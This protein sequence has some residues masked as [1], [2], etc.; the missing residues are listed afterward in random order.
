MELD[1]TGNLHVVHL[2]R[3]QVLVVS[4]EGKVIRREPDGNLTTSNVAFAEPKMDKLFVTGGNP[5]ALSRLDLGVRG[6]TLLPAP[7]QVD[8]PSPR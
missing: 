2:G 7:G 1:E 3:R 4:P 6:L 5:G 8:G